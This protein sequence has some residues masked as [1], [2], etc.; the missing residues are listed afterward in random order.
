MLSVL[1][2]GIVALL[3]TGTRL[4]APVLTMRRMYTQQDHILGR[5]A[6]AGCAGAI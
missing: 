1:F 4:T 3:G 6:A 2:L 5:N